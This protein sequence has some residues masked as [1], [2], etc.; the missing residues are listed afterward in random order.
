MIVKFTDLNSGFIAGCIDAY[1]AVHSVFDPDDVPCHADH[2]TTTHVLWRWS[3]HGNID[4]SVYSDE[5]RTIE[6]TDL[7]RSHLTRTYGIRFY[8]NGHYDVNHFCDMLD[9]EKAEGYIG[10]VDRRFMGEEA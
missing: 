4:W 10:V 5:D 3:T 9:K 2:F 1:G 7:I 6:H 8:E